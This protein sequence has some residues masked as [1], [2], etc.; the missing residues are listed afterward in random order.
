VSKSASAALRFG[1]TMGI[2]NLFA[3]LTY[4][5]GA[6][7]NGPFLGKLGASA[8]AVGIIAG[9]GEF[10]GYALRLVSGR[11]ADRQGRLWLITFV[12]Y[13]INLLAVPALALANH[14]IVAAALVLAERIGRAIRKPTVEAMLSYS[15]EQ[16]GKGWAF[17]LNTALDE[18]R[19]YD[20]ASHDRAEGATD[21]PRFAEGVLERD[22]GPASARCYARTRRWRRRETIFRSRASS[23]G[24]SWIPAGESSRMLA[25]SPVASRSGTGARPGRDTTRASRSRISPTS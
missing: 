17:A 4:E 18:T 22:A 3:D 14:W 9:V 19:R 2:V 20:R 7:I 5:G 10:L 21:A 8:A 24:R 11:V 13:T 1:V 12:G 6:S 23:G 16:L 15:S 25:C